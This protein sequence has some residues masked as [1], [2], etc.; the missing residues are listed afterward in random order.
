[1]QHYVIICEGEDMS[2]KITIDPQDVDNQV[3]CSRVYSWFFARVLTRL[4]LHYDIGFM[5]DLTWHWIVRKGAR[6]QG[7]IDKLGSIDRRDQG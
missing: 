4:S 7:G 3:H 2:F 5:H 1:M 6:T